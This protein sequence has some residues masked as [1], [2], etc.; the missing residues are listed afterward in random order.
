MLLRERRTVQLLVVHVGY[1]LVG[2]AVAVILLDDAVEEVFE[3]DVRV[4]RAS[5]HA[6]SRVEIFAARE[7]ASFEGDACRVALVV[8]LF[9]NVFCQML[10]QQRLRAGRERRPVDQIVRI[11]QE[12]AHQ[13]AA[14][15]PL[16]SGVLVTCRLVAAHSLAFY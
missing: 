6:N 15:R 5:I 10:G 8:V 7:D 11:V 2:G 16:K 12:A 9:P 4:F 1:V 3:G 14:F 13:C